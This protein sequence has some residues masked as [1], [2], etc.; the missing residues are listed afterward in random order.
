MLTGPIYTVIVP[1]QNRQVCIYVKAEY[2]YYSVHVFIMISA[3][4]VAS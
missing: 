2:P 4:K 1:L 3:V